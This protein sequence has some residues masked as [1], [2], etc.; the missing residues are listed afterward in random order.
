VGKPFYFLT[1][2]A[3]VSEGMIEN[4]KIPG[5]LRVPTFRMSGILTS[6]EQGDAVIT[7]AMPSDSAIEFAEA[8]IALARTIPTPQEQL[9]PTQGETE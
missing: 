9:T 3:Q 8:L 5:A 1:I 2:D 4:T 6:H 7:V